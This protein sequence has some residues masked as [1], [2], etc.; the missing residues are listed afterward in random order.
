MPHQCTDGFVAYQRLAFHTRFRIGL[1]VLALS[2]ACSLPATAIAEDAEPTLQ[3]YSKVEPQQY[4]W[5]WIRWLM[6]GQIDPK[7]EM[8]MGLVHMEP[9]QKNTLH[10][11]PNSAEYLHILSGTS[12]HLSGNR[13]ITLKPGDTLRIPKGMPHQ[14]RTKDQAFE[15]LIVYDTPT[16]QMVPVVDGKV[17]PAAKP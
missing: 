2:L 11:H 15:A 10:I 13:W 3:E 8:T 4:P 16:R 14:A 5:G 7:A 1:A 12:E 17:P 6:N 9:N